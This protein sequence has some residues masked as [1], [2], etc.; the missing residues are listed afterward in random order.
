M[1]HDPLF[2]ASILA[3]PVGDRET[4]FSCWTDKVVW[5]AHC[6]RP[7]CHPRARRC[8]RRRSGVSSSS[9]ASIA[10]CTRRHTGTAAARV[11]R[12]SV[13]SDN[14]RRRRSPASGRIATSRRRRS[15]LSAAVRVV[16]SMASSAATAAMSGASDRLSDISN[17]NW[18]L[19]KPT[20]RKASSKRRA[21]T[22]AARWT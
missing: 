13:V 11:A 17:E 5:S 8:R 2:R 12:P 4:S 16:R 7:I 14:R 1:N 21:R 22:R 9:C 6:V 19:V 10:A 20:R 18:P 15:G 3:Q